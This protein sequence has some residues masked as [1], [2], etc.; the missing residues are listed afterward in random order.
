MISPSIWESDSFSDLSDLAKIVFISLFSHADDEGRGKAKASYIRSITFPNDE[1]RRDADIKKALSEIA[2]HMSVQFYKISGIEY[3]VMTNWNEYQTINKPTK[4]K[5][6]PP[7]VVGEGGGIHSNGK[8]PQDY[9][10]TTVG[11]PHDCGTKK[12]VEDKE[13]INNT[14]SAGTHEEAITDFERRFNAFCKK[15]SVAVDNYSPLLNELDFDKLDT[16][17]VESTKFLQVAPVARTVSWIIKNAASIY[18]GKYR[19]KVPTREQRKHGRR[20]VTEDWAETIAHLYDGNNVKGD[21]E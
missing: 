1:N 4:S 21:E 14:H 9:G 17:Y 19:D 12:E 11:L 6:P 10:N 5:F 20:S 3:Y 13:N 8:L 15:W 16:A 7:P 18:A 2:L